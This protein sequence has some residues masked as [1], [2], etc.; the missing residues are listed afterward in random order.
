MQATVDRVMQTYAMMV[1]LTPEEEEVTRQELERFWPEW[2]L[3]KRRLRLR[4]FAICA[5][6]AVLRGEE[7]R[8]KQHDG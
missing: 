7:W 2:T 6:Q 3:T 1:D 8:G 4:G 5:D